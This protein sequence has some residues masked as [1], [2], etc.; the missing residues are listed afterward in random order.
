M[1]FIQAA[2][3]WVL[4]SWGRG[5]TWHV[6]R[7]PGETWT[8]SSGAA[9]HILIQSKQGNRS[10]T[11]LIS[12]KPTNPITVGMLTLATLSP[13]QWNAEQ[14]KSKC[15]CYCALPCVPSPPSWPVSP[16]LLSP[17]VTVLVNVSPVLASNG[18]LNIIRPKN[19]RVFRA[20]CKRC[21]M[22]QWLLL[23]SKQ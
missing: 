5:E 22:C 7:E 17:G 20:M 2:E 11:D 16:S 1:I 18:V 15:D 23:F 21:W 3:W 14:I 12:F 19:W 6:I 8:R 10:H 13:S 4:S 9:K